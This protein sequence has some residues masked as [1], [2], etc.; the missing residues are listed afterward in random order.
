VIQVER[1]PIHFAEGRA[2]SVEKVINRES[3]FH[4][5]MPT[6]KNTII[7]VFIFCWME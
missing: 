3:S 6:R 2:G 5:N 7:I 1:F 4:I